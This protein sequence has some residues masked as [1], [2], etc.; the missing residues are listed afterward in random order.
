VLNS[1]PYR[2]VRAMHHSV[3]T[4]FIA[5]AYGMGVNADDMRLVKEACERR[6]AAIIVEEP[7][8]E[9]STSAAV[10]GE[11]DTSGSPEWNRSN[12]AAYPSAD[13]T[14]SQSPLPQKEDMDAAPQSLMRDMRDIDTAPRSSIHCIR[15]M[16]T[17]P[18]PNNLTDVPPTT[19]FEGV[20]WIDATKEWKNLPAG[21]CE[22]RTSWHIRLAGVGISIAACRMT[23][24]NN[25]ATLTEARMGGVKSVYVPLSLWTAMTTRLQA[26]EP[27]ASGMGP[28][29]S[30][31]AS[32]SASSTIRRGVDH[33]LAE[34]ELGPGETF[35]HDGVALHITMYGDRTVTGM[36]ADHSDVIKI[37]GLHHIQNCPDVETF[38][39]RTVD[40]RALSVV[41]FKGMITLWAVYARKSGVAS[42]L[43]DWVVDTV[44]SVQY[45]EAEPVRQA[46]YDN[47][48]LADRLTRYS[49]SHWALNGEKR[50]QGL[51][52]DEICSAEVARE[53][54]PAEVDAALANLP[55]GTRLCDAIVAKVGYSTNKA[56]RMRNIRTDMRKAFGD[57]IDP[58]I[59]SFTRCPGAEQDDLK[60]LEK[61]VLET[62]ISYKLVGIEA[63][64]EKQQ[65][66]LYLITRAIGRDISSA[67]SVQAAIYA[68]EKIDS[69]NVA[70]NAN[71]GRILELEGRARA[72]QE[73]LERAEMKM[74]SLETLS[75]ERIESRDAK[76]EDRNSQLAAKDAQLAL[77]D[78]EIHALR[79]ALTK[80]LPSDIA[81]ILSG[82]LCS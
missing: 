33:E 2:G 60:P 13:N 79:K 15:D 41:N 32:T 31:A 76:I 56:T 18:L 63:Y 10:D 51:Y 34:I 62:F 37:L 70:A 78:S 42:A 45:G 64:V 80:T 24:I 6:E 82:V 67:L 29:T 73:L 5:D 22:R 49:A 35:Q 66:E 20:K 47:L 7:G 71:N 68:S 23:K 44:F 39:A 3:I 8:C 26:V 72:T 69:A 4:T 38:D 46:E 30:D 40:G 65:D 74:E 57:K 27:I 21:V 55:E 75:C 43:M 58:R 52:L 16:D 14:G 36:Y 9:A 11:G 54:W 48:V 25:I 81:N 1:T 77:K 59:V 17:A 12:P 19:E 28:Y 61:N 50:S 53:R